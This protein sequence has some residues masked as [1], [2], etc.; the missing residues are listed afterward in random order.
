MEFVGDLLQVGNWQLLLEVEI[1]LSRWQDALSW[2]AGEAVS[3]VIFPVPRGVLSKFSAW[4]R[5]LDSSVGLVI[6]DE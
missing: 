2:V 1:P 5:H 4:C 6:Q 3:W